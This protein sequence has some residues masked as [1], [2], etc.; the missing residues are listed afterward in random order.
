MDNTKI[1]ESTENDA[2]MLD[3]RRF[4]RVRVKLTG[5]LR[6][7]G[8]GVEMITTRNISEGGVALRTETGRQFQHGMDVQ[9]YLDGVLSDNEHSALHL[10]KMKIVHVRDKELGLRFS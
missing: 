3:A 8:M 7:P 2:A 9:L 10:Y 6:V 4:Q 5:A 1:T